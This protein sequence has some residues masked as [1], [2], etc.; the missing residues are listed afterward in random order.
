MTQKELPF[1][2]EQE[3]KEKNLTALCGLLLYLGLFEALKL[4]FI[5]NKNLKVKA[6]RQGYRDDQIILA[7][8][9]L[10]LAGGESV[11]DIK[12]L[13]KDKGFCQILKA[14]ELRGAIGRRREEIKRRWRKKIKNTVA[15]PSSIFRYLAHFH[16]EEEEKKRKE[17]KAFIPRSNDYLSQF[18]E[19]NRELVYFIHK[20]KP[21]RR[22][23]LDM[24][25]TLAATNKESALFNYKGYKS[26][27]PFNIWW[28]E[29]DLLLHTEFRDG[30]VPAGHDQLRMLEESLSRLPEG[31]EE[32]YI[33]SDTA[34]YQHKFLKYCDM[35][36]NKRFGRIRFAIGCDIT[37][38]FKE[39]IL[40]DK[41]LEWH[42]IYKIVNGEKK[43]SGQEW[44]EVCFVPNEIGR[45]KRG[46]EYRYIAVR[47]ELEQRVLPGMEENL[48]L[49][50]PTMNITNK[51]YK[52]TSVVT[53]LDW[54]GEEVIHWY[55]ERCGK[56]EEVHSV[57]KEDLAGGRFPSSDFGENAA[58]WWIMILALNV[59][60]IMKQFVLGNGWKNKR[61]KSIRF[62]II[63]IPGRI[64]KGS[65]SKSFIVR[66][67]HGHPSLNLL[68]RARE[69]IME[70]ACLPS[71]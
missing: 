12:L 30:N 63:H 67:A 41:N 31:V 17:G 39:S 36:H 43:E 55:R 27:Q 4:D 61:M 18:P 14:M 50:F 47:E 40:L 37:P 62:H 54:F 69:K 51:R 70:L 32:V 23:T 64:V 5:V 38:A 6:D 66:I 22:A 42:P 8:I 28:F 48:E 33:R 3:K 2:Y 60:T 26:Y 21:V 65:G 35:G 57:M 11:S 10:N 68:N 56:S 52:L 25:A 20:R 44:A 58:W 7:L 53:N 59:Q 29:L 16:N 46:R 19:I 45:S 15:T 71:G 34:G 49:P 24:D 9:L 13:E 1:K